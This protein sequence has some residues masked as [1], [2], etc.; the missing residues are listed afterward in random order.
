MEENMHKYQQD[1]RDTDCLS[2]L[3]TT[4]TPEKISFQPDST[5]TNFGRVHLHWENVLT[6]LQKPLFSHHFTSSQSVSKRNII[7]QKLIK[8]EACAHIPYIL[9]SRHSLHSLVI[10]QMYR[11]H[12]NS[13][14]TPSSVDNFQ[15][16]PLDCLSQS[17]ASICAFCQRQYENSVTEK[18]RKIDTSTISMLD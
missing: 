14:K 16:C 9:R 2:F 13:I 8:P 4:I 15:K 18:A 6:T 17:Y 12:Y 7:R 1:Q 3:L 10:W 5:G 11:I